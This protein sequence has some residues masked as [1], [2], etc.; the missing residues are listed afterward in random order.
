MFLLLHR[1]LGIFEMP[2]QSSTTPNRNT[3]ATNHQSL[4][5]EIEKWKIYS[6]KCCIVFVETSDAILANL[7]VKTH[8]VHRVLHLVFKIGIFYF[9]SVF[10][11]V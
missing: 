10:L 7:N 1:W 9:V 11:W 6:T 3:M 4:N 2:K 5:L 8:L